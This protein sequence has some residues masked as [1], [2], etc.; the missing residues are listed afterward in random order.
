LCKAIQIGCLDV[1]VAHDTQAIL[2][3]VVGKH[4]HDVGPT[5]FSLQRSAREEKKDRCED[6]EGL[7]HYNCVSL[8]D[9]ICPKHSFV[10][11]A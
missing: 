11:K 2:R 1:L 3:L 5:I 10:S 6:L 9:P 7:I 8:I 4:K